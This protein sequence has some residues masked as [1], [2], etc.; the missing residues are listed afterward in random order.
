MKNNMKF[1]FLILTVFLVSQFLISAPQEGKIKCPGKVKVHVAAIQGENFQEFTYFSK[2]IAPAWSA[3]LKVLLGGKIKDVFFQNGAEIKSG[4]AVFTL[5]SAAQAKEVKAAEAEVTLWTKTLKQR[6]SWKDKNEK[7]VKQ[8]EDKLKE[9]SA[10]LAVARQ[11]LD[12]CSVKSPLDGKIVMLTAAAGMDVSAGSTMAVIE[13]T[14]MMKLSLAGAEIANLKD[15]EKIF[16]KFADIA[17]GMTGEVQL[18]AP[19]QADIL[20]DNRDQKLNAGLKAS[21]KVLK[22]EYSDVI[23]I[24]E[25]HIFRDLSGAYAY[26]VKDKRANKMALTLGA[27]EEGR[28]VVLAGLDKGMQLIVDNLNCLYQGKKI[29][30]VP[31][32]GAKPES[33]AVTVV[34]PAKEEPV[35]E[36]PAQEEIMQPAVGAEAGKAV[37]FKIGLNFSYKYMTGEGFSG[38]YGRAVGPGIELSYVVSPKMDIWI[39]ATTSSKEKDLGFVAGTEKY[40]MMPLAVGIKYFVLQKEKLSA[41][42]GGGLNY[43]I[44]KDTPSIPEIAE[45]KE[46][47]FGFNILGGGNYQLSK[48]IYA[49]LMLKYNMAKK[50]LTLDPVADFDLDLTNFE[51]TVGAFIAF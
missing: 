2:E 17:S 9:V 33:A 36:E 47:V 29:K 25:G 13:N 49:Q 31:E 30:I 6:K 41:F 15:K 12:N 38:L 10:K 11:N 44:F 43:I 14:S 16:V 34:E 45:I 4:D 1:L 27:V 42:V 48:N 39:A 7:A 21:C 24:S 35:K 3:E 26:V 50:K 20:L 28:S 5:E 37:K 40:S 22:K 46:N 23:V 19:E 8:A 32:I 18:L 51:L